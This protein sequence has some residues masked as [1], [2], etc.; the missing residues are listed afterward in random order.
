M[1]T[2]PS[3]KAYRSAEDFVS[4]FLDTLTPGVI[5][6]D[7]FINWAR[8]EK[9]LAGFAEALRFYNQYEASQP[10]RELTKEIALALASAD[11]PQVLLRGALLLLGHSEPVLVTREGVVDTEE[12]SKAIQAGDDKPAFQAAE[13]LMSMGLSKVLARKTLGDVMF[14]VEVGLESH[15][16]KGVGGKAFSELCA[17]MLA[18][19]VKALSRKSAACRLVREAALR[20]GDGL[21]KRADF[22]IAVGDQVRVGLELNFYVTTGSKPTEIKRAYGNIAAGL[23]KEGVALVWIT[24]GYGYTRMRRSLRDAFV[25]FPNIYNYRQAQQHLLPD[26]LATM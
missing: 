23:A 3:R 21:S 22:G 1:K 16:R 9:K 24:D 7:R 14:G 13:A 10:V 15:A 5:P 12:I 25:I 2:L 19:T 6:R 20:Y 18:D 8:I 17:P 4:D 26:L 11:E